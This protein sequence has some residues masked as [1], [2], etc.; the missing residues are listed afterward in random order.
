MLVECGQ[1]GSLVPLQSCIPRL[2]IPRVGREGE[3]RN[4]G[5]KEGRKEW[6]KKGKEG[7]KEGRKGGRRKEGGKK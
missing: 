2:S 6:R 5:R 4:E 7:R 1:D 3:R